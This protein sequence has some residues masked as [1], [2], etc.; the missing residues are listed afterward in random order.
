MPRVDFEIKRSGLWVSN[1]QDIKVPKVD[2]DIKRSGL[3]VSSIHSIKVP[4]VDIDIKRSGLWV[5]NIHNTKVPSSDY[6]HT[7]HTGEMERRFRVGNIFRKIY[8]SF[9]FNKVQG[10]KLEQSLI[11]FFKFLFHTAQDRKLRKKIDVNLF[12]NLRLKRIKS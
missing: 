10:N 9:F 6:F 5:S 2:I 8:I 4:K 1:I 11:E 3:W 12:L 7:L